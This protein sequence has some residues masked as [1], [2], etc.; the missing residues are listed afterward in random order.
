M[1]DKSFADAEY[2]FSSCSMR[3]VSSSMLTSVAF[4][5]ASEACPRSVV[6]YST[7]WLAAGVRYL[8]GRVLSLEHDPAKCEAWRRNVEEA[9]LEDWAELPALLGFGDFALPAI[10]SPS[11]VRRSAPIRL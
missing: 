5:S 2:D 9:G 3:A 10:A 1:T 6:W 7:L 11:C 8:G 4:E